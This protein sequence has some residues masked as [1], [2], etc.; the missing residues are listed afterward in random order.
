MAYGLMV[1]HGKKSANTDRNIYTTRAT[2]IV[3][4]VEPEIRKDRK[5]IL[6]YDDYKPQKAESF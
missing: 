2:S 1:A 6:I 4:E 5:C 3:K